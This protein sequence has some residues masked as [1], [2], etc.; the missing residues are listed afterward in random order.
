MLTKHMLLAL[1]G[2]SAAYAAPAE[3]AVASGGS[4]TLLDLDDILGKSVDE[5]EDAPEFV[6]PPDGRYMLECK[7]AKLEDYKVT[8][9]DGTE[10]KRLRIKIIHSVV[11]TH[12]LANAEE[13]PVPAGSM[14]S[15]Q[16]MCNE[17]GLS[18]FKRQ[19]K[20]ILGADVIKGAKIGD[21]LKELPNNHQYNADVR[22]KTTDGQGK[23][24]GKKYRNVQVRIKGGDPLVSA[25]VAQ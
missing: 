11:Q 2:V 8:A 20:N 16:F 17:Q 9:E 14:F 7:E 18:Y 4:D 19:A 24:K 15:E 1:F 25:A 22:V 3:A 5:V 23:N 6:T 13:E 10:E 12:E 21:I